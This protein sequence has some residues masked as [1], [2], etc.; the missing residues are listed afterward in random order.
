MYEI[1]YGSK[2]AETKDLGTKEVA[3]KIRMEIKAMVKAGELPKAKYSVTIS[4]YSGGSSIDVKI[5]YVELE[6]FTLFNP[7]R[8]A[9]EKANPHTFTHEP[10]YSVGA[11][12][13]DKVIESMLHSYNFDGSEPMTDY[14]CGCCRC[15]GAGNHLPEESSL[16]IYDAVNALRKGGK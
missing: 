15:Q 8:L 16:R 4:R 12:L 6:G 7:E 11:M 9:F 10:R 3:A 13:L 2:Y 1:A 14:E 5:G